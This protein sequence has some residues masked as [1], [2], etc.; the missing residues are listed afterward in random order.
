MTNVNLEVK[1]ST[2]D[3]ERIRKALRS[4]NAE[5]IGIDHQIDTYFSV[6][7]GRLKLREGDI[8]NCIVYYERENKKGPKK[9]EFILLEVDPDPDIKEIFKK[10]FGILTVVDKEREIY[11]IDNLKFHLDT[12]KDLGTFVEIE[13]ASDKADK[14]LYKQVKEYMV[15]FGIREEDL[16]SGSYSDLLLKNRNK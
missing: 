10:L 5:F 8:E 6:S 4:R 7:K 13:A 11:F 3:Q 14:R 1:A 2:A 16:I 12:V 9:C 15:L